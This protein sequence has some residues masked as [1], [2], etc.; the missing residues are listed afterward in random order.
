MALWGDRCLG[1]DVG[2]HGFVFA[3]G[4]VCVPFLVGHLV[5]EFPV[6]RVLPPLLD[7]LTASVDGQFEIRRRTVRI[8]RAPVEYRLSRERFDVIYAA[9][10]ENKRSCKG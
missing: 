10:M 1:L 5:R 4:L 9:R 3:G 2:S 6:G 8:G 7:D